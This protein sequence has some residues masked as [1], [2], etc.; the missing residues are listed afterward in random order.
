MTYFLI[1]VGWTLVSRFIA[2]FCFGI[3]KALNPIDYNVL[4][5]KD[6]YGHHPE[7]YNELKL[8]LIPCSAELW[9]F[10]IYSAKFVTWLYKQIEKAIYSPFKL[11]E[12]TAIKIQ[13]YRTIKS[14]QISKDS[15]NLSEVKESGSLSITNS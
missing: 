8:A 5:K 7:R 11:G 15:G 2:L 4:T 14:N 10:G 6:F 3:W 13:E 9:A 1:F 12:Y